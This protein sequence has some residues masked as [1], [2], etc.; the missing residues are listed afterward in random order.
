[1]VPLAK[2]LQSEIA[3]SSCGGISSERSDRALLQQQL[4][5][6]LTAV[7]RLIGDEDQPDRSLFFQIVRLRPPRHCRRQDR[8][9]DAC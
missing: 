4:V 3:I 9:I 5:A 8:L 6:I 1:M 2:D 7:D